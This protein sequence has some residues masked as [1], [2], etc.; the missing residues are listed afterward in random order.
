VPLP[1]PLAPE[2]IVSHGESL[3]AVQPQPLSDNTLKLPEAA[4]AA[5]RKLVGEKVK[6]QVPS[7]VWFARARP[8]VSR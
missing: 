6:L 8:P 4:V 3:A 5:G 1:L 7:M 2:A